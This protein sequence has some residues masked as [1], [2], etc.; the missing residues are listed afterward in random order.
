LDLLRPLFLFGLLVLSARAFS[1]GVDIAGA[2][3]W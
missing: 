1:Q 2:D 3:P